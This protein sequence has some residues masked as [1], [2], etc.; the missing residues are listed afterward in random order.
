LELIQQQQ[1]QQHIT[2]LQNCTD[3]QPLLHHFHIGMHSS[4]SESGP[5]VLIEY[6]AQNIPFVTFNTGEVTF[7]I[8]ESLP[9]FIL[10]D[11]DMNAWLARIQIILSKDKQ[12]WQQKL[13]QVFDKYFSA[14]KYYQKSIAIYR[15]GL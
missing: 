6:L 7:Q 4:L 13:P 5:L 2:I 14:E 3:V 10:N 15:Q 12:Y 8:S 1:L 9:E 11:F